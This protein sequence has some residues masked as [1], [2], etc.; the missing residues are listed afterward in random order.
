M[1]K[2]NLIRLVEHY[3]KSGNE[4]AIADIQRKHPE[5]IKRNEKTKKTDE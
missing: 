5:I 1:T 2:A 3:E 4:K